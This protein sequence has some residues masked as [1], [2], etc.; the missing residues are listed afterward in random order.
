VVYDGEQSKFSNTMTPSKN[1]SSSMNSKYMHI[2]ED[3]S[4]C[5]FNDMDHG[6]PIKPLFLSNISNET[7]VPFQARKGLIYRCRDKIKKMIN[8]LYLDYPER[9]FLEKQLSSRFF[10]PSEFWYQFD[11]EQ[12]VPILI[13]IKENFWWSNHHFIPE[14]P[15]KFVFF[16][17]RFHGYSLKEFRIDMSYKLGYSFTNNIDGDNNLGMFIQ[18]VLRLS[19]RFEMT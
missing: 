14:D 10:F 15:L 1:E 5:I 11:I 9:I 2:C 18:S 12:V 8:I 19:E 4:I 16:E 7:P 6:I 3:N 17:S 13:L